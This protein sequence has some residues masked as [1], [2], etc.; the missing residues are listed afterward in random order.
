VETIQHKKLSKHKTKNDEKT[1]MKE[2]KNIFCF[3]LMADTNLYQNNNTNK[4]N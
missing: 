4:Q 3:R 1:Q 2:Y